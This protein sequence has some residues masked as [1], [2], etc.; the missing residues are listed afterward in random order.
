MTPSTMPR[1]PGLGIPVID[2][3]NAIACRGLPME[4]V[5]KA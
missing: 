5:T 3:R 4:H 2:T 1:W